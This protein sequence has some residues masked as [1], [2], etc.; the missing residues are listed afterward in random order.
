MAPKKTGFALSFFRP[1]GMDPR[2]KPVHPVTRG[3]L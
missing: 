1:Q 3:G 2:A